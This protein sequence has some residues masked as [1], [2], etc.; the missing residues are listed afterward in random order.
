VAEEYEVH[1]SQ[2]IEYWKISFREL[3]HTSC[4]H[5]ARVCADLVFLATILAEAVAVGEQRKWIGSKSLWRWYIST[6]IMFLDIIHRPVFILKY[7]VTETGFCLRLQVKPTQLGTNSIDWAKLSRLYL[8]T[9]TESSL[10][11]LVFWK[12]NRTIFLD[13]NRMMHNAQKHN[14]GLL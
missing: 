10:R 14:T 7:K 2:A 8:K 6:N 13:E 3:S 5:Y 12:I 4:S 11:N 9:E 1:E